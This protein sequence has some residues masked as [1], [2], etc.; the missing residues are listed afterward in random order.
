MGGCNATCL[1]GTRSEKDS[2]EWRLVDALIAAMEGAVE[3]LYGHVHRVSTTATEIGAMLGLPADDLERLATVGVLHDVGKIHV[4]PS[5][6]AK[7]GPLIGG[8][9]THMRRHPLYGFAMTVDRFDRSVCEAILFHHE[10]WDGTGYPFGLERDNIPQLARIV[11]VADAYD[12]ITSHRSYQPALPADHA[13]SEIRAHS[14]RQF[15]P[16]A[17]EAF[18]AVAEAGRVAGFRTVHSSAVAR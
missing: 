2:G 6:L 1:S 14:G 10:R 15:D 8:E 18:V 4:D 3:D 13:L 7:P 17:V 5:L 11:L 9:V 12:A 16:E